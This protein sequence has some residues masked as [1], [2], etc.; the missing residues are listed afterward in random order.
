MSVVKI[1]IVLK[2]A[3]RNGLI[4]WVVMVLVS[5]FGMWY[6]GEMTSFIDFL[7]SLFGS[8]FVGSII[9]LAIEF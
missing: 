6:I 1:D 8:V 3:I 2:K 7:W 9:C 5:T 4:A